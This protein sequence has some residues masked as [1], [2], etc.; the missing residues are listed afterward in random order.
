M[1]KFNTNSYCL[2]YNQ[3]IGKNVMPNIKVFEDKKIRTQWNADGKDW[4]FS[5]VDIV[6]VLTDKNYDK[7]IQKNG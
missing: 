3:T 4:Y 1:P 2:L 6:G 7:A 5:V